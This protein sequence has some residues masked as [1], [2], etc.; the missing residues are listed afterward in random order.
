MQIYTILYTVY[1][2]VYTVYTI[3]KSMY[4]FFILISVSRLGD[5]LFEN[6]HKLLKY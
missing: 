6:F 5:N 1:I 3:K 2:H 4:F